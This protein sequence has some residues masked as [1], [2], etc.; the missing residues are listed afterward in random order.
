MRIPLQA[1]KTNGRTLDLTRITD[2]RFDFGADFGNERGRIGLD[3]IQF[4][5]K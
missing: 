1:F 4:T 2:I 3:D 5:T